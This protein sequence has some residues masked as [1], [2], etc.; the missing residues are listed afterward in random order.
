LAGE[1]EIMETAV[2]CT[3]DG[4]CQPFN[5]GGA[6]GLGWTIGGQGH[7]A[8]LPKDYSNTN[9]VAEYLALH[10]VLDALMAMEG[11]TSA[12][13][14]GDSE[15]VV[16]Q[17]SGEYAVKSS[18]LYPLWKQAGEKL[19]R[20]R[21]KGVSVMVTWHPRER[22]EQADAESK[23]ALAE[24][25]VVTIGQRKPDHGWT[26]RLGDMAKPLGLS[27]VPFGKCLDEVGLR[28]DG[29]HPTDKAIAEGYATER[30][31]GFGFVTDWNMQ[32]CRE[33]VAS[34]AKAQAAKAKMEQRVK[35]MHAALAERGALSHASKI[36]PET[37]AK[38]VLLA[39]E[40]RLTWREIAEACG[41]TKKL[42]RDTAIRHGLRRAP[43]SVHRAQAEAREP[44]NFPEFLEARCITEKGVI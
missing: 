25:G 19:G 12:V 28:K 5:P 4:A 17:V 26:P 35:Q 10:N 33:T 22:N 41:V 43:E 7:H 14:S 2:K 23:S 11:I 37:E 34:T 44:Q 13:V 8:F 6:M 38:I 9:N 40:G 30:F 29:G 39:S 36:G 27:A 21:Q 1:E 18:N 16:N 32:K 31:N 20:L 3:F 15:L 24:N 42:A